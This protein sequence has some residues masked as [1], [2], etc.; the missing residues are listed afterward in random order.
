[1]L[2]QGQMTSGSTVMVDRDPSGDDEHPLKLTIIPPTHPP[3]PKAEE[4]P[5]KVGVTADKGEGDEGSDEPD[6]DEPSGDG[7]SGE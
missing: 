2:K 4:E 1:V 5:A 3:K 7:E 6:P